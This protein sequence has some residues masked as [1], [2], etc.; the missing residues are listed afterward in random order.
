M[1]GGQITSALI[2]AGLVDEIRL[3]VYPLIVGAGQSLF[4]AT[5][6]R[7]AMELR[8]VRQLDGGRLSLTY[9]IR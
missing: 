3:I 4:D 7:H 9:G 1:G 6:H 5:E 2:G 8:N